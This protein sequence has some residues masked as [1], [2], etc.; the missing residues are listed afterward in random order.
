MQA[1]AR[2]FFRLVVIRHGDRAPVEAGYLSVGVSSA[3]AERALW[4]SRL[5]A[6]DEVAALAA[7]FPIVHDDASEAGHPRDGASR[8]F[9]NLTAQGLARAR[10]LGAAL[11]LS[12]YALAES[13]VTGSHRDHANV[14]C[15]LALALAPRAARRA[16]HLK[17]DQLG[18]AVVQ[19]QPEARR[20]LGERRPARLH[21]SRSTPLDLMTSEVC[22]RR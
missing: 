22:H 9:S 10:R 7:R 6:P 20:Q 11:A 13:S 12:A 1:A 8:P 16:P 18:G 5:P 19:G 17:V 21:K 14:Y 3:A 2:P 15:A 4:A